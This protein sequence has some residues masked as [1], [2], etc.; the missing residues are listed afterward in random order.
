MPQQTDTDR[1]EQGAGFGAECK[2]YDGGD[3]LEDLPGT[4]GSSGHKKDISE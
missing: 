1:D 4:Q 2:E 3:A